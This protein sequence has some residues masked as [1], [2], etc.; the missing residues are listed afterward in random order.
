MKPLAF[1]LADV[2]DQLGGSLQEPDVKRG[3]GTG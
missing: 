3:L 2:S 1:V